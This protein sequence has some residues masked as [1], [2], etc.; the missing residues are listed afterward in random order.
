MSIFIYRIRL[1]NVNAIIH[2]IEYINKK[3]WR[4]ILHKE[5]DECFHIKTDFD[6]FFDILLNVSFN[7]ILSN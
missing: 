7:Q 1:A 5:F 4:I 3:T 2:E 6:Q